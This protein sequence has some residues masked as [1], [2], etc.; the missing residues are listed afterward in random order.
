MRGEAVRQESEL[1]LWAVGGR[2]SA[3]HL[4]EVGD[5]PPVAETK[6]LQTPREKSTPPSSSPPASDCSDSRLQPR[7]VS[8]SSAAVT[9]PPPKLHF[10][11]VSGANVGPG[12][13]SQ[14]YFTSSAVLSVK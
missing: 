4:G 14:L 13:N 7:C 2:S 8:S 5:V 10:P 3:G 12:N 6:H 1:H 11:S 9:G